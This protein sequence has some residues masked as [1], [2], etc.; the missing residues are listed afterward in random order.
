MHALYVS[1]LSHPE[2]TLQRLALSCLLTYK[3]RRPIPHEDMLRALLD[4]TRWP[5]ELTLLDVTQFGAEE[6]EEVIDVACGCSSG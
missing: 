4:D 1:L 3:S 5:D 6:Q 2:R